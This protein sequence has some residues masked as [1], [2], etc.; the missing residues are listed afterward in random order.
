V[1]LV[2]TNTWVY[3]LQGSRPT[4]LA[5]FLKANR[6]RTCAVVIGELS[7]GSGMPPEFRANLASLPSVPSPS[8]EDTVAFIQRH[9]HTVAGAGIGWADVQVI[10]A[11]ENAGALLYTEDEAMRRVWTALGHRL[12]DAGARGR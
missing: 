9:S 1:I 10:V 4:R 8:A 3:F 5:T 11:A 7:L 2:D 6:V 12:A